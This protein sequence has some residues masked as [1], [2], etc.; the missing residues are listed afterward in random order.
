MILLEKTRG[1]FLFCADKLLDD[2]GNCQF[3]V[4]A[5]KYTVSLHPILHTYMHFVISFCSL[6]ALWSPTCGSCPSRWWRTSCT[7]TGSRPPSLYLLTF[8]Q[9]WFS[10]SVFTRSASFQ[11]SPLSI[12]SVQDQDKRLQ[13]LLNAC[14]KLPPANNN[15]F[16]WVAVFL[17]FLSGSCFIQDISNWFLTNFRLSSFV[18]STV[19][20]RKPE[21]TSQALFFCHVLLPFGRCHWFF[22][23]CRIWKP[24]S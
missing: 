1:A 9:W 13:A 20:V 4:L 22:W 6:Q 7:T 19:F 11:V 10:F 2:V 23:Y 18:H 21:I 14:E 17:C 12:C 5:N 8:H 3:K 16:K 15:N 24:A